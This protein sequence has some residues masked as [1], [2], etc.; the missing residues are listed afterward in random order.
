MTMARLFAGTRAY[1]GAQR[2]LPG[3][4]RSARRNG[5]RVVVIAA[6]LLLPPALATA[7]ASAGPAAGG[8]GTLAHSGAA[9]ATRLPPKRLGPGPVIVRGAHRIGALADSAKINIDVMLAPRSAVALEDYAAN[10][11]SPGNSLYHRYLT[12]GQFASRFGPTASAISA[13]ESSL[14]AAG[15]TP[16]PLSAD[17]LTLPVTAPAAQFAKAFSIGFDRYRLPGGRI[18]FANTKAPLF[19]GAAAGYVSAVVG[20]DTLSRPRPLGPSRPAKRSMRESPQVV[21]GGPQPCSTAVADAGLDGA[22]TADQLASAYNFSGLYGAGDEGSGVTVALLELEPDLAGDIS[23]YQSCYGTDATVTYVPEDGGAGSGAGQGEAALDIEDVI[24]L[25]PKATVDVYQAPNTNTGWIDDITAIVDN[26]A[27][28]VMSTSWGLCESDAGSSVIGA[29]GTLFEQAA[30]EGQSVFAAAGDDGSTDCQTSSLAVDDPGSQP[31][32]TSVGGTSLTS[33]SGPAQTVWNDSSEAGGAGGGGISSFQAM[34]S[35]Q[36]SAPASLNVINSNSSG[37]PCGAAS[38]SYCREVPDVS[39][40]AD[41]NHGYLVYFDGGWTPIGGT[42][43]AAPLWAAFAA[44]ADASS[45]CGGTAIGFANP[46]LYQAAATNYSGNFSDITSGNN[47]YTPDGY[48]GG[49]YPA[50]TAYDMASGL[51][52]PHGATL[53]QALCNKGGAPNTVTVANPGSQAMTVGA[54]ASLQITA[55]DSASGQTLTYSATGLPPG[56]SISSSGLISGTPTT[57]GT[58]SVTVTATDTTGASGSAAFTITVSPAANTVT[59]TNPGSQAMTVGAAASLQITATDS[60]SGQTLTYS[61]TGLPPGLSISSSGLISGTPTT[62]GTYSVTVTAT[63]T[64]GASGSAAF[65]ITVSPA[66]NTVTVTN[67]GSQAMTVGAAASL[68]IT[69]TDSAS[70]QT[71][72]YSATGLPP[73][74]S[75]SSSGLISGTPTTAGTYSV[76]VTATDTTGASGSAAFTITVSPAANTVTVTTPGSQAMTVGAAASLQITAT[77]SA[78]GQTLTYSATGLP[79]GLSISSSGLI[80]GTPTTAGTYSVTVTATD[81]TGASGS[82]AFT[83][84]V[85]PAAN[86]V[87]VTTPGSQAMTV[88]AAAS[89]QITA[90]DSASGQT[91]TYSATGLPP[92]LSISSSGLIS[93]TPTTAGTYSVTVTAT[94]TT[95]ASGSAAFTITV[96]PAPQVISFTAPATGTVGKSATLTAT[97]GGSGNP[98]VFTVDT[99]SGAGVCNVSGTNGATVTYTAAG[100]CVIDANQAGNA[101]Y[102]AAP[103]VTATITVDQAPAFVMDSPP[104]TAVAGQAYD[105]TFEASGTP[106]PTYA[107]ATGAP[108][109]LSVNAST[110]EVT[111]TPPAGTTSFSYAVTAT[112]T[113]GT[114]TAGPFTVTVGKASSNADISA[115]LSCPA[116]MTVGGTGTCTL[117]VANAGPAAASKVVAGVLLPAALSKV[118]CTSSCARHANVFTWSLASLA[119][120]ASAKFAI[121]VKASAAGKVAVLAAAASQNPDPKPLNNISIQQIKITR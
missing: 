8:A 70:G 80:S 58:Y 113:A 29:E 88:G 16:G 38:R 48:I 23:A 6:A 108:P 37:S 50:G 64:T 84:T 76:T 79:P 97:G 83:I 12:V 32:V 60:A 91:L 78:S 81:T 111:G 87:T 54:A 19:A 75:I 120:G 112:N 86:T 114:A 119:S 66:A 92:G 57:A 47:D 17:H 62:A 43:A 1:F 7:A 44:L 85:S 49:L 36:S 34:P 21:T 61:A 117:T 31:Y 73:G 69:A 11:S 72:T 103:Q 24:G 14:R 18:A 25:A 41:E 30:T 67:P 102:T 53:A 51:G 118:S 104:L 89:L 106:A 59:V 39:A 45:T 27:V 98:V 93:G 52:T 5:Q 46:L 28:H 116:A 33:I 110:G 4:A 82:A 55:T 77:D 107:L 26:S 56:L 115:A 65:T 9:G 71:L 15:L 101:D 94:D 96:S 42:S 10:V 90:T 68:Q 121:T 35:Y 74:L 109:W 40:S 13:V 105:Y 22:Y 100:S 3:M 95:G 20:L 99:S 63:D 2:P